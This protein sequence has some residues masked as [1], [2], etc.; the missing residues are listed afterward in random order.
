MSCSLWKERFFRLSVEGVNNS[1]IQ[2]EEALRETGNMLQD[3]NDKA[4]CRQTSEFIRRGHLQLWT[5]FGFKL[6]H[7]S[8]F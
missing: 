6:K 7:N 8:V 3:A 1:L 2:L 5:M 4:A